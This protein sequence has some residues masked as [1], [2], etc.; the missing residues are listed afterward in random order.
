LGSQLKPR[1]AIR[2]SERNT[3]AAPREVDDFRV[4]VIDRMLGLRIRCWLLV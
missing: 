1:M 4:V 2:Q 3:I